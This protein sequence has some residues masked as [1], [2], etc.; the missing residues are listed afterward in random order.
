M[1]EFTEV[2]QDLGQMNYI[3]QYGLGL[4]YL[5]TD[6]GVAIG[7][8]GYDYGFNGVFLYF[9]EIETTLAIMINGYSSDISKVFDSQQVFKYV[10]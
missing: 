6:N 9:P 5:E 8:Y 10:F 1:E 4:M 7:H 3:T 2:T